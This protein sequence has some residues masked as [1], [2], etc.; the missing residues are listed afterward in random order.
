MIQK[1]N[2][3]DELKRRNV[4]KAATLYVVSGWVLLQV[5]DVI[6][7]AFGFTD[8]AFRILTI[9]L[10]SGFPI[11]LIAAWLYEI[12]ESGIERTLPAT[13]NQTVPSARTDYIV[14]LLLL[15]VVSMTSWERISESDLAQS[16]RTT[17]ANNDAVSDLTGLPRV[18]RSILDLGSPERKVTSRTRT[19]ID[20]SDDGGFLA[21]SYR[22]G[23]IER[24]MVRDLSE[25]EPRVLWEME[26]PYTNG[27]EISPDGSKIVFNANGNLHVVE[28]AN[29]RDR[30]ILPARDGATAPLW[31][32]NEE[33]LVSEGLEPVVSRVNVVTGSRQEFLRHNDPNVRIMRTRYLPERHA[34]LMTVSLGGG[35]Y[36]IDV[37]DLETQEIKTLIEDAIRPYYTRTGHLLFVLANGIWA[38][39]FDLENLDISGVEQLLVS[40]IEATN[41]FQLAGYS[42]SNNGRLVYIPNEGSTLS[43]TVPV[44]LSLEG[45][46]TSMDFAPNR[47]SNPVLSPDGS[48]LAI[49][50]RDGTAS[51]DLWLYDM[52]NGVKEQRT[53]D[54]RMVTPFWSHDSQ[55]LYY[56]ITDSERSATGR[57]VLYET[58][59]SGAVGRTVVG[60][61]EGIFFPMAITADDNT[62]LFNLHENQRRRWIAQ[63]SLNGDDSGVKKLMEVYLYSSLSLSPNGDYIVYSDMSADGAL[64]SF[65]RP[66]PNLEDDIWS[67]P[68]NSNEPRWSPYGSRIFYIDN[69]TNQ[70]FSIPVSEEPPFF[71]GRPE[72]IVDDIY[73]DQFNKPNYS[74]HPDGNAVLILKRIED[75]ELYSSTTA[76]LVDNWFIELNRL[77]PTVQ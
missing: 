28:V 68:P 9:V 33:I 55:K 75:D 4:Y 69:A 49:K 53:F 14:I 57:S 63:V 24:V 37:I 58:E 43:L 61:V 10:L 18:T 31:M 47:Y 16:D 8:Q 20:L 52:T 27:L 54:E 19:Y 62:M 42:I 11:V 1:L 30:V 48:K 76:V 25:L 71:Q 40:N 50:E 38:A 77:V 70:L 17:A 59:P 65:I 12:T 13:H 5:S 2:F 46:E 3:F 35:R 41:S 32:N 39:P 15:V 64:Q 21:Y 22:E 29:G 67:L 34:A 60:E 7:P 66:Y 23:D 56:A 36:Q 45:T 72:L 44:L 51:G 26:S 74:L 6:L 73:F